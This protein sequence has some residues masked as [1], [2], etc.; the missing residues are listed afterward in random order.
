MIGILL[1]FTHYYPLNRKPTGY[2]S[3]RF[4]AH[5][6]INDASCDF[7]EKDDQYEDIDHYSFSC[8]G[9]IW[10]GTPTEATYTLYIVPNDLLK[11]KYLKE[12]KKKFGKGLL[13]GKY[14]LIKGYLTEFNYFE[15]T[16]KEIP[17]PI[18]VYK[19]FEGELIIQ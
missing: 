12:L 5:T 3:S 15:N 19:R 1:Y 8:G 6:I 4:L 13:V 7:P 14:Y 17:D 10:T 9:S 16:A 11:N 18:K 2:W